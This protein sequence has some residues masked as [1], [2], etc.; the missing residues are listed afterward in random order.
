MARRVLIGL[1]LAAL[2]LAALPVTAQVPQP[3]AAAPDVA[4]GP[5]INSGPLT[6]PSLRGRVVLVEFWTYG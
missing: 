6:L 3:G 1:A 4:G 2:A 5:W